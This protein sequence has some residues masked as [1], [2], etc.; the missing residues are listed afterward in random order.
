MVAVVGRFG[1]IT[2][3]AVAERTD[4]DKVKVSRATAG[5]V[6]AGLLEQGPAPHDGRARLLRLSGKGRSVHDATCRWRSNCRRNSPPGWAR[7]NG[8]CWAA[9]SAVAGALRSLEANA[10]S[11]ALRQRLNGNSGRRTAEA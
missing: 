8:T 9:A 7:R 6:A 11:H 1:T 5:L 4:M 3:S 2:P 10:V